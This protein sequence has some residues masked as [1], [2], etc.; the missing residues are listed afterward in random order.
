MCA[1][2]L[3]FVYLN[4]SRFRDPFG[5]YNRDCYLTWFWQEKEQRVTFPSGRVYLCIT[6]D[7]EGVLLA[8]LLSWSYFFI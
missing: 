7:T 1:Y 6:M 8:S 4:R 2:L 3:K 5:P